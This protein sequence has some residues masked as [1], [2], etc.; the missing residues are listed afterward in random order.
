MEKQSQDVIVWVFQYTN[1][2]EKFGNG[3]QK[4]HFIFTFLTKP[5]ANST[6]YVIISFYFLFCFYILRT[7]ICPVFHLNLLPFW[8]WTSASFLVFSIAPGIGRRSLVVPYQCSPSPQSSFCSWNFTPTPPNSMQPY[9]ACVVQ[10]CGVMLD[11]WVLGLFNSLVF[12]PKHFFLLLQSDL[13]TPK[14]CC[15]NE[16]LFVTSEARFLPYFRFPSL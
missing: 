15:I 4:C 3:S 8:F 11:L 16:W 6:N 14:F 1:S 12:I 7:K 13:M 2:F 10:A 5:L 9:Y